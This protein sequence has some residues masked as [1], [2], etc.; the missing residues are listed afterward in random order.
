MI[1]EAF[2]PHSDLPMGGLVTLDQ[3]AGKLPLLL[4]SLIEV[5]CNI[6]KEIPNHRVQM[7]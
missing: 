6:C 1:R 7:G 2:L 4:S 3:V 5:L